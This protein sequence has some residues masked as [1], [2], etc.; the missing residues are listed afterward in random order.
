[1]Q[2]GEAFSHHGAVADGTGFGLVIG[3]EGRKRESIVLITNSEFSRGLRGHQNEDGQG[4]QIPKYLNPWRRATISKHH[5][6][7]LI[8]SRESTR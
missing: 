2:C 7:Y 5:C 3:T 6:S 1:M 8:R 4:R